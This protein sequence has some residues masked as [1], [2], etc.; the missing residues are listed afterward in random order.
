MNLLMLPPV[1]RKSTGIFRAQH[2]HLRLA[3]DKFRVI[4][5]QLRHV[6]LA[7]WSGET[8]VE[9]QQSTHDQIEAP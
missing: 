4:L 1:S 2:N 5:A 6:P 8:M 7:E 9:D 3:C